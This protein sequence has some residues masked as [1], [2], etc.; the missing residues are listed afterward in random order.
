ME[1]AHLAPGQAVHGRRAVVDAAN[2]GGVLRQEQ[3]AAAATSS[4]ARKEPR[5]ESALQPAVL[6]Q[7]DCLRPGAVVSSAESA[8]TPHCGSTKSAPTARGAADVARPRVEHSTTIV[9]SPSG[10]AAP[11]L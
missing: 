11:D 10:A 8:G 7:A 5:C 4:F 9:P 1:S 2:A 6:C 3:Q